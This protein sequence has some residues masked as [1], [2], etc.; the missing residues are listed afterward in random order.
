MR[1]KKTTTEASVMEAAA[2]AEKTTKRTATKRTSTKK[3]TLAKK[4]ATSTRKTR[5]TKKAEQPQTEQP[6]AELIEQTVQQQEQPQA[7]AEDTVPVATEEKTEA[8]PMPQPKQEQPA[9]QAE[10]PK[11][12][13]PAPQT[14]A[15]KQHKPQEQP[16]QP[17]PQEIP[18]LPRMTI[19][20]IV[21]LTQAPQRSIVL[22]DQ[23]IQ[24][25]TL[26][27]VEK[28]RLFLQEA[29]CN[30]LDYDV[31]ISDTNIW[32]ELLL[33]N[34]QG[35]GSANARLAFER[36]LDFI[37]K[38]M[39]R[40]GGKFVIMGETYEEID[41]FATIQDPV[42]HKEADFSD[43]VVCLNT[44]AR[45]AKR[46]ILSQQRENR[47]RI[48]GISSESHHAAF[49]D[50]A[51]VRRVVELF[52][53]GKKVLLITNDASVAIRSIALCDD[54]QRI[55]NVSDEEWDNTYALVRPMAFTFEDLRLLD[56]YTKQYH[57]IHVAAGLAWMS[58]VKPMEKRPAAEPLVLSEQAF[59]PGDRHRGDNLF[60]KLDEQGNT[61]LS[62]QQP[63]QRQT[64]KK[65]QQQNKGKNQSAQKAQTPAAPV[66]EEAADNSHSQPE[67]INAAQTTPAA[68]ATPA[69]NPEPAPQPA[70]QAT[71][72]AGKKSRSPRKRP[73]AKKQA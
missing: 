70:P 26:E 27:E 63:A 55:N 25:L 66:A 46:L 52:A 12:E 8:Q 14:E 40:R 48:E 54:L 64:Q 23:Q 47:L 32:L 18:A 2:V 11:Q 69:A 1:T 6:Q 50:P 53:S 41:R 51:I 21:D 34:Y 71:P 9:P 72:S 36:Q 58:D 42:N 67:Q 43:P 57:Y 56:N 19:S 35:G 13:Q 22:N 30:V 33:S 7:T 3:P 31:V 28:R 44:A 10:A 38:M 17:K 16:K 29:L 60:V 37:S 5:T 73:A 61:S 15:P 24:Q 59:R 20:N 62:A 65:K 49:A 4:T 68:P 45:L 39:K